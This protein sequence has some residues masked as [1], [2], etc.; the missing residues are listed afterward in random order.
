MF[1]RR[2]PLILRSCSSLCTGGPYRQTWIDICQRAR[3]DPHELVTKRLDK[4]TDLVLD[5]TL[6]QGKV[7]NLIY[8]KISRSNSP[9][10]L[11]LRVPATTPP[12][13]FHSSRQALSC[14]VSSIS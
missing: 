3:V 10:S 11:A 14:H 8:A 5:A 12:L 13:P 2:P 6:T 4:L 7:A 9:F 1:V